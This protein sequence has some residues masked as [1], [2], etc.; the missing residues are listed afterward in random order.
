MKDG[1]LFIN[2]ARGGL[3]DEAA[4]ADALRAGKPRAAATDVA[5]TEPIGDDNL[6]LGAPNLI[7][8]PHMAWATV[9]RA[10]TPH[11]DDGRQHRR[12]RSRRTD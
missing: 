6:L 12:F 11:A 2:T 9:E 10:R 4:L 1:A 3:V 7:M 5:S 8:T